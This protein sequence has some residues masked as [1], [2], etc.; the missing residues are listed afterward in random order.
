[1]SFWSIFP[2][3][4]LIALPGA[5]AVLVLFRLSLGLTTLELI[6]FGVP[7]WVSRYSVL[8]LIGSSLWGLNG[9]TIWIPLVVSLVLVAVCARPVFVL[10]SGR[11]SADV[12]FRSLRYLPSHWIRWIPIIVVGVF[13]GRWMWFWT[14]ACNVYGTGM[15]FG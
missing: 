15:C 6:S 8:L 2:A 1:M 9:W 12:G 5:A 3:M 10:P 7:L 14:Q 13:V 11:A 4:V